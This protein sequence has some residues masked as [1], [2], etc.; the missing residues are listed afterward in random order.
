MRRRCQH[1]AASWS[2]SRPVRQGRAPLRRV[3]GSRRSPRLPRSS[4]PPRTGSIAAVGSSRCGRL[5]CRSS[6]PPRTGSIAACEPVAA[7][8]A[9]DAASSRP[10]RTGSIAARLTACRRPCSDAG[11]PVRQ[12]RA[13]LRRPGGHDATQR[14]GHVVPSAKDGLH[15]GGERSR[16]ASV[17][18]VSS[19]RPPRTGSIAAGTGSRRIA[20]RWRVVPSAKDGLHCG[21]AVRACWRR[22]SRGRP[23]RQGRAPLRRRPAS[24]RASAAHGRPVRQGRAP[25]RPSAAVTAASATRRS[26]RPPRTG[27]IAARSAEPR[28]RAVAASSRPPRTG[29]IA[30]ATGR[31]AVATCSRRR[32]VRQGRAPLR[33]RMRRPRGRPHGASS[34]PPRTGSIAAACVGVTRGHRRPVVP[35][36][37]DGLHCGADH[38]G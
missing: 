37:K 20:R 25:L 32:P 17:P 5:T 4:R 16:P 1:A 21:S 15:C 31:A 26:S 14:H 12:G 19:S 36:A 30:A 33:P 11:R 2:P 23:V 7:P 6:R 27:S 18:R 24:R 28:R 34:R 22:R 13:P 10:P 3:L 29:S 38:A 9:G 8:A 35:S